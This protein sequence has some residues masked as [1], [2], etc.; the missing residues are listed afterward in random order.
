MWLSTP[1]TP[2]VKKS[3]TISTLSFLGDSAATIALHQGAE[4]LAAYQVVSFFS[5]VRK[6]T[7]IK[8]RQKGCRSYTFRPSQAD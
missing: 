5:S 1:P 3:Q 7:R 2:G 4:A 6:G 8:E